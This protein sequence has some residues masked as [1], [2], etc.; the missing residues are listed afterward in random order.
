VLRERGQG[1]LEAGEVSREQEIQ[2]AAAGPGGAHPSLKCAVAL[3]LGQQI[4]QDRQ[5]GLVVQFA[6]DQLER[7]GVEDHEQLLVA[8]SQELLEEGRAAQNSGFLSRRDGRCRRM[9]GSRRFAGRTAM[10]DTVSG[11]HGN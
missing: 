8:E 5:L 6:R 1:V 11:Y 2:R 4:E 9:S 3:V 7:I 10:P